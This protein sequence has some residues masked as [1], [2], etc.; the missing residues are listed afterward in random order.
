MW[1]LGVVAIILGILGLAHVI[2]MVTWLA[3]LLLVV[4]VLLVLW[5]RMGSVR[6]RR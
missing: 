3:V 5:D 6:F 4:G 1:I 2:G